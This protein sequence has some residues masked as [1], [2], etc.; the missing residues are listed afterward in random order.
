MDVF[1]PH[2]KDVLYIYND[3][4]VNIVLLSILLWL[5]VAG[6]NAEWIIIL[7]IKFVTTLGVVI[8]NEQL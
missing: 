4:D 7:C 6:A 3:S 2:A 1:V 5:H 8:N